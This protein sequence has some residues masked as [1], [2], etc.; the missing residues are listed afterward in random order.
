DD[1]QQQLTDAEAK[2]HKRD[3]DLAQLLEEIDRFRHGVAGRIKDDPEWR[4]AEATTDEA[5]KN[6]AKEK[7]KDSLLETKR[8]QKQKPYE[9]DPLFMYLWNKK[10]G[11]SED[12]SFYIVRYFDRMVAT[13]TG[14]LGARAN[15]AMLLEIPMRLREHANAKQKDAGA[16]QDHVMILERKA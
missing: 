10:F 6:T 14:Y 1:A 11:Q 15:Y 16:C 3:Q 4:A 5:K 12:Q 8:A 13:L 2:K 7:K 9:D